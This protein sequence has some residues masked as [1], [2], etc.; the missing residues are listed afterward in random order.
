[1]HRD[2]INQLFFAAWWGGHTA[3]T[4]P[5]A[6]LASY[7]GNELAGMGLQATLDLHMP[8][9]VSSCGTTSD[10][11]VQVGDV[12]VTLDYT[13][14]GAPQTTVFFASLRVAV[15]VSLIPG[16][17]GLNAITFAVQEVTQIGAQT[18][19]STGAGFLDEL[20]VSLLF[21]EVMADLFISDYL[22]ELVA[23]YPATSVDVGAWVP[24]IPSGVD[25]TFQPLTLNVPGGH[26]QMG[27]IAKDL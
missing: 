13:F 18:M 14:A 7:L 10:L 27:G 11:E 17:D 16:P 1:M 5:E 22:G 15:D 4:I 8:P 24:G 9:M 12:R 6:Y 26:L 3:V 23:S 20:A 25:L 2:L 21:T 19:S